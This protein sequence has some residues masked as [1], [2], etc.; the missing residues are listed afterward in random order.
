[1]SGPGPQAAENDV[2]FHVGSQGVS[3]LIMLALS[4]AADDPKQTNSVSRCCNAFASVAEASY[5]PMCW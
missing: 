5:Y 1:M 4:L 3:G 2:R